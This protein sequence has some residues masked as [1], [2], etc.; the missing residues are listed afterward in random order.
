MAWAHSLVAH[1]ALP[2]TAVAD[3][4]GLVGERS[5]GTRSARSAAS[6]RRSFP[7]PP[8]SDRYVVAHL[9]SLTRSRLQLVFITALCTA[10]RVA[11]AAPAI[12]AAL[13]SLAS[14]YPPLSIEAT[15]ASMASLMAEADA[16]G[17]APLP[18]G[19]P[20]PAEP[21]GILSRF[22][23]GPSGGDVLPPDVEVVVLTTPTALAGHLLG[24][25]PA[26]WIPR[27]TAPM[28]EALLSAMM[29]SAPRIGVMGGR[30]GRAH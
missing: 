19:V 14:E 10:A 13:R 20:L 15:E 24:L 21:P 11:G 8:F 27:V 28:H 3:A 5:L 7:P 4:V 9:D 18:H 30:K 29:A 26:A 2:P 16:V 23:L 12:L 22:G 1:F 17:R 25:L 6:A